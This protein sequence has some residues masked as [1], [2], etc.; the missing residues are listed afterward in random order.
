[1]KGQVIFILGGPGVGKGTQCTALTNASSNDPNNPLK[2]IHISAGDLL[3]AERSRPNSQYAPII[4][5]NIQQGTIVP[6]QI[7]IDLLKDAMNESAN[8][9]HYF[10]IDGF[11]RNVSQGIAFEEQVSPCAALLFFDCPEDILVN[12]LLKRSQTSGRDDD[13]LDSIRKRL[14]TYRNE[15]LPVFEHYENQGKVYKID[16]NHSIEV[17]TD[18]LK[19]ILGE[20]QQ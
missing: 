14:V 5:Q 4:N 18:K 10:L 17:I 12:R 15:T 6:S 19:E 3:R 1:M 13:N 20:I 16:C 9:C 11:P 8:K 7:T 2:Y